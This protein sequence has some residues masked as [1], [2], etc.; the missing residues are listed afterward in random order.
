MSK[1]NYILQ[2]T[3]VLFTAHMGNW[4]VLIYPQIYVT[5]TIV[6]KLRGSVQ[7]NMSILVLAKG[8]SKY[9]NILYSC[10]MAF[11]CIVYDSRN[12]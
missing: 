10:Y 2:T 11:K 9:C 12:L 3:N 6:A 1:D 5:G 4:G 8:G 7:L